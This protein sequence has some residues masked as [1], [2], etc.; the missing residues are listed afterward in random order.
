MSFLVITDNKIELVVGA[1]KLP[2]I[3]ELISRDRS[4]GK[5]FIR[6]AYTYIYYVYSPDSICRNKYPEDRK[7]FVINNFLP[8][9]KKEDFE[10]NKYVKAVIEVYNDLNLSLSERFYNDLKSDMEEML[11]YLR[12]IPW[13]KKLKI[14]QEVEVMVGA[15]LQKIM[16]NV[17]IDH[18]NSQAKLD[19]IARAEKIIDLE[20]KLKDKVA[21]ELKEKTVKKRRLFENQ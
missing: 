16:V 13:T 2:A 15:E 21:K 20:E 19:A 14:N 4:E 5:K 10:E 18:D 6:D 3:E 1:E 17:T 8:S 11:I 9:R 12:N 7:Q